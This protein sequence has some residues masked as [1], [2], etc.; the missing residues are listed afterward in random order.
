MK[1]FT[2]LKKQ[3]KLQFSKYAIHEPAKKK[4]HLKYLQDFKIID[5]FIIL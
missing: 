2:A 5:I 1:M 3:N 4:S